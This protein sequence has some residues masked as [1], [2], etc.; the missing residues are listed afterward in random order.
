MREDLAALKIEASPQVLA[1]LDDDQVLGIWPENLSALHLFRVA[2]TQWA[3]SFGG[4]IGLRYEA[5]PVCMDLAGIP[6]EERPQAFAG[7]QV[8]EAEILRIRSAER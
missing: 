1:E 6:T 5:L 7:V 8:M 4:L 3:A 2:H